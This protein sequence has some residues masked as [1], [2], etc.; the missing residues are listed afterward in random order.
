MASSTLD[1]EKNAEIREGFLCPIC[2]EDLGTVYQLQQHFE[3]THNS[4]EDSDVLQSFKDFLGK[5]K[6]ILKSDAP[7]DKLEKSFN[8]SNSSTNEFH[9]WDPQEIGVTR[10]HW[11]EFKKLRN[12]RM[13]FYAAETNK[14]IIR[15]DKIISELPVEPGKRREHEQ[16]IVHWVDDED[17]KLCPQCAKSFNLLRRKHHCRVCGT[18]QC[19][20]CS[21]FLLLSFARKL[22]N[23]SYV[24]SSENEKSVQAVEFEGLAHSAFRVLKRTGSATSLT[25]LIDSHTGEGHIR[26]CSYC[27]QLLERREQQIEFHSQKTVIVELYNEM[28]LHMDKAAQLMPI[29]LKMVASLSQGESTYN[30]K[31]A[32]ECRFKLLKIAEFVDGYSK[33]IQGLGLNDEKKSPHWSSIFSS[34]KNTSIGSQFP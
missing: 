22:T 1:V 33:K 16:N 21:Q 9:Y 19:H 34:A 26:V 30:L 7:L 15:L 24:P 17:V 12:Q 11:Q 14:L 10:S 25:S 4:E 13:D 29:F 5:A 6:K 32:Q 27:K 20:P 28:R 2:M 23:P 8:K 3:E 18:I 31:D